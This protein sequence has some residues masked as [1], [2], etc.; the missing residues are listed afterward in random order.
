[1]NISFASV[2][3]IRDTLRDARGDAWSLVI[4]RARETLLTEILAVVAV[5]A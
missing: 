2:R 1:M 4:D 3:V 5:L